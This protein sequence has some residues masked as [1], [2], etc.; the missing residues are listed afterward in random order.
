MFKLILDKAIVTTN[1]PKRAAGRPRD[2]EKTRAILE[3]AWALFLER[4]VGAV[5]IEAIAACAGVSKVTVYRQFGDKL[6][7]FEEVMRQEMLKIEAAQQVKAPFDPTVGLESALRVFGIGMLSFLTTVPA[8]DFYKVLSGESRR[9]PELA[10]TFYDLGPGRT[11]ANLAALLAR[12][13]PR[14]LIPDPHAAAEELFGLWQGLS[15][16]QIALGI[17]VDSYVPS[18]PTRVSRGIRL[19]IRSYACE[20]AVDGIQY[21]ESTD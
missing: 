17:D 19:F 18:I 11:I 14:L 10:R 12:G 21:A 5:S 20:H 9:H 6:A 2:T 7:I 3:A 1:E 15:N 4:G 16:Y 8:I 13:D